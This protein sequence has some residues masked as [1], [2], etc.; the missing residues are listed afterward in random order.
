M[1]EQEEYPYEY[2]CKD[3]KEDFASKVPEVCCGQCCSP[4]IVE[5]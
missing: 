3:C 5:Q 2:Y 4:N 1:S